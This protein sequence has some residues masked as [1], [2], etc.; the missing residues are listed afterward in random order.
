LPISVFVVFGL[1]HQSEPKSLDYI[2]VVHFLSPSGYT[3]AL[4]TEEDLY[5][6]AEAYCN[7]LCHAEDIWLVLFL[8]LRRR[9]APNTIFFRIIIKIELCAYVWWGMCPC[10][11]LVEG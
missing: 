3:S 9:K 1:R 10:I 8:D 4:V 6:E 5:S 7:N 11:C 2:F